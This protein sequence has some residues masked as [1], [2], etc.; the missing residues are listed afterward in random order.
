MKHVNQLGFTVSESI[1]G[2]GAIMRYRAGKTINSI[3]CWHWQKVCLKRRD[4]QVWLV[5]VVICMSKL[6]ICSIYWNKIENK[7]C[8]PAILAR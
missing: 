5:I 1:E 8:W 4:K 3:K 6:K 2:E 7:S